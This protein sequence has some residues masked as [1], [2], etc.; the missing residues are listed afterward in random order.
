M[1]LGADA[2]DWKEYSP[3]A[4]I[5]P[6]SIHISGLHLDTMSTAVK[7][8]KKKPAGTFNDFKYHNGKFYTGM[9]V[10]RTHTWDYDKGRWQETKIS[11]EVWRVFY[12]VKKRRVGKAPTGSGAKV[13]TG[14]H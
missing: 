5:S 14:Y 13:G 1:Q 4:Q 2:T 6:H 3:M 10:G 9:K 8:S 11:P 7:K 12:S